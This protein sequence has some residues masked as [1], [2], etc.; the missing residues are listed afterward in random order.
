[1]ETSLG[2]L[3]LAAGSSSRMGQPKT[4]LPW[5]ES[6]VLETVLKTALQLAHKEIVVIGGAHQQQLESLLAKT[7]VKTI[8]NPNWQQGMGSSLALG[9]E[10]LSE[11]GIKKVLVLLADMPT[12]QI[13]HLNALIESSNAEDCDVVCSVYGE[14]K[15][16]PAVFNHTT[17]ARLM[18]LEGEIGAK[19]LLKTASWRLISIDSETPFEDL[20]TPEDY[21]SLK[22]K[23]KA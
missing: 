10:C 16:V 3:I 17:F 6:T 23:Y 21:Q 4:L 11:I 22:E 7:G 1:M 14:M 8:F 19:K 12:I 9:I 5:A 18:A 20:D 15:G 2:I 13:D